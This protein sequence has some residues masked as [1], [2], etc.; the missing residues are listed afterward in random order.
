MKHLVRLLP[1]ALA[2][3]LVSGCSSSSTGSDNSSTTYPR[4][5]GIVVNGSGYDNVII[6]FSGEGE[7]KYPNPAG[8]PPAILTFSGI[9]DGDNASFAIGLPSDKTGKYDW[10][11]LYTNQPPPD[12][13]MQITIGG[14]GGG[15]FESTGGHTTVDEFSSI[16]GKVTGSFS[17]TLRSIDGSKT[18]DV[19]GKFSAQRY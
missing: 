5:N 18:L 19:N 8:A 13:Y 17:G 11:Y 15:I 3:T 16:G 12:S 14:S 1:L 4:S 10:Q 7:A 2:L 9:V 6:D